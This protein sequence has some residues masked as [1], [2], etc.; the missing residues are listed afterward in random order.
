MTSDNP[1]SDP[2]Y[3]SGDPVAFGDLVRRYQDSLFAY[4]G[5]MGFSE[6]TAED[7]A[8]EAFLRA[9][10]SREKYDPTKAAVSTWLFTIARNVAMS[11]LARK[12]LHVSD[13]YEVDQQ[14]GFAAGDDPAHQIA[15][16]E[17]ITRLRLALNSLSAEDREVIATCYTPEIENSIAI[18]Q[19]SEGAL[20]TRLSRA[21]KRLT[22]ALTKLDKRHE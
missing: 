14:A 6:A 10:K 2:D 8:Q 16:S 20:R 12:T 11:A 19:C 7:I 9:W 13:E 4:L 1:S 15:V 18:L 21:R 3:L 17:S 5:R 22:A